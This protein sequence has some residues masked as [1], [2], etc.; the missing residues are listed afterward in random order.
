M[1]LF[2]LFVLGYTIVAGWFFF[3][4]GASSEWY[5]SKEIVAELMRS[6]REQEALVEELY[7]LRASRVKPLGEGHPSN[8]RRSHLA[9]VD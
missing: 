3:I 1:R 4:W 5:K 8:S 2:L 9:I 6:Y 7:E